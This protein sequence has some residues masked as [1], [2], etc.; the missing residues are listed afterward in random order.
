M[1]PSSSI[2]VP[3]DR[4]SRRPCSIA[5]SLPIA[6]WL[7]C[8]NS[9]GQFEAPS[10]N[11]AEW[12]TPPP[13]PALPSQHAGPIYSVP[14]DPFMNEHQEQVFLSILHRHDSTD[15]RDWTVVDLRGYLASKFPV[16]LNKAE[17]D[18]LGVDA[19]EPIRVNPAPGPLG[20]RLDD[21]LSA[22]ELA[23]LVSGNRLVITSR[24]A[25]DAQPAIRVYDVTPLVLRRVHGTRVYKYDDLIRLLQ[26]TVDPD[27]WLEFGGTSSILHFT[28]GPAGGERGLLTIACPTLGHLRIQA[29]LNRL[30]G[31]QARPDAAPLPEPVPPSMFRPARELP[32][33]DDPFD[34]S[35]P[36]PFADS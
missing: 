34:N 15:F 23:Y 19:V 29:L 27:Q 13:S 10:Q 2:A 17:L 9:Y 20:K 7:L 33:S 5:I 16:F 18:L 32:S 28:A 14:S 4:K 11:A 22:L 24:D 31:F 36:D 26:H 35:V 12:T 21:L 1:P 25:V 6:L 30:N 3:Q 8:A